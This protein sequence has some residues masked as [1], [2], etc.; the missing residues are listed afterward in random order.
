MPCHVTSTWWSESI[1]DEATRESAWL[2]GRQPWRLT[3]RKIVPFEV[4][5][6][7]IARWKFPNGSGKQC[8]GQR[9]KTEATVAAAGNWTV[10]YSDLLK[11]FYIRCY[12]W[13]IY[14]ILTFLYQM[15]KKFPFPFLSNFSIKFFPRLKLW[16][17]YKHIM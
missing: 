17:S 12:W 5:F 4:C 2:R 8:G 6:V 13:L 7:K 10:G 14:F 1:H 11:Q 9:W 3:N 15:L 16:H